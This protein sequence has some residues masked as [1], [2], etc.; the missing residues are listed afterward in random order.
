MEVH[1]AAGGQMNRDRY[2]ELTSILEERRRSSFDSACMMATDILL[3]IP[4]EAASGVASSY[5]RKM[6]STAAFQLRA[7]SASRRRSL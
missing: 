4:S 7:N 1:K 5:K 2:A 3:G 6:G